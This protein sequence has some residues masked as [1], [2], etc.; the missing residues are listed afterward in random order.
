MKFL[1]FDILILVGTKKTTKNQYIRRGASMCDSFNEQLSYASIQS[2]SITNE[3][4]NHDDISYVASEDEDDSGKI[5]TF[6]VKRKRVRMKSQMPKKRKLRPEDERTLKILTE[7]FRTNENNAAVCQVKHC[8]YKPMQSTKP[9][10]LKRH[11]SQMHPETYKELFPHDVSK[12]KQ[13]EMD[14]Y[15]SMQDA[16]ELVTVNGYPFS[17]LNAS[18]MRG[19]IQARVQP[20]QSKCRRLPINR[21]DIVKQVAETSDEIRK[22]IK[23]EMKGKII[24]LMFDMCTI[25]YR[26]A[27]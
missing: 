9:S 22:K 8:R 10:N 16:I 15:N 23:S 5:Q 25:K 27:F 19:F 24:S 4:D 20:L 2:V 3:N 11:L 21:V 18:G 7:K 1:D 12:E 26:C 14:I 6:G 17:M 13:I